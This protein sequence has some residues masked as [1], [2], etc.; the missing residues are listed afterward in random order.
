MFLINFFVAGSPPLIGVAWTLVTQLA[1]Y[2]MIGALL[3]LF[4]RA[5]WVAIAIQI[6]VCSVILSIVPNYTGLTASSIANVGG[7][8]SA[9]ALGAR[10][11]ARQPLVPAGHRHVRGG[12]EVLRR[13]ADTDGECCR[14]DRPLPWEWDWPPATSIVE[15]AH[16]RVVSPD[17]TAVR[18]AEGMR[19][20][21]RQ[22]LAHGD[23]FGKR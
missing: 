4:R 22:N 13:R 21:S 20:G 15:A 3:V 9:A 5:P 10:L 19:Q 14:A 16:G 23:R 7:A 17:F 6:T 2:A 11:R 12:H 1:V 18:R 8:A